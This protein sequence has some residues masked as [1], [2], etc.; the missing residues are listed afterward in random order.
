MREYFLRKE[1]RDILRDVCSQD[2]A[3]RFLDA[4]VEL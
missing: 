4:P 3:L 1:R 2:P